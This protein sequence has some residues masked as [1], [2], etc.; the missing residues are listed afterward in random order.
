MEGLKEKGMDGWEDE[1]TAAEGDIRSGEMEQV[2]CWGRG[3]GEDQ[4]GL[5]KESVRGRVR[6]VV[7]KKVY[8]GRRGWKINS[9]GAILPPSATLRSPFSLISVLPL[10]TVI[11]SPAFRFI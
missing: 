7:L 9:L 4:K 8:L 3:A 2:G 5:R 10:Q 1:R 11:P 6:Q